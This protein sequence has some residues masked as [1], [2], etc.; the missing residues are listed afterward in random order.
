MEADVVYD[1]LSSDSPEVAEKILLSYR[2]R[3]EHILVKKFLNFTGD[4]FG[5]LSSVFN[6]IQ[7]FKPI[8]REVQNRRKKRLPTLLG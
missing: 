4:K 6:Q 7:G 3:C 1:I 2:H 5:F 8:L